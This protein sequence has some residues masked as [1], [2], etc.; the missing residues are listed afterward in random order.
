[1]ELQSGVKIAANAGVQSTN[2]SYTGSERV[3]RIIYIR[4]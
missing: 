3:K 4:A 2:I 1:M